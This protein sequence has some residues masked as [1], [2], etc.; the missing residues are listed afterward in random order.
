MRTQERI[1][2]RVQFLEKLQRI[3]IAKTRVRE[4]IKNKIYSKDTEVGVVGV[5]SSQFC[6]DVG[7]N[8]EARENKSN[9]GG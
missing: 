8:S 6:C 9:K 1:Y 5:M 2:G 4:E 7:V 3:S